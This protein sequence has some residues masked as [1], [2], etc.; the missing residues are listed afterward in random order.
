MPIWLLNRILALDLPSRI[1]QKETEN[2]TE[3]PK[4]AGCISQSEDDKEVTHG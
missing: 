3:A 2:P 4:A 1:N